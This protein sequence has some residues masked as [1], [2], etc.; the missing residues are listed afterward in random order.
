MHAPNC[1]CCRAQGYYE[2]HDSGHIGTSDL[3]SK[4][5]QYC[6]QAFKLIADPAYEYVTYLRFSA[7]FDECAGRCDHHTR[8]TCLTRQ[9][10]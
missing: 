3:E 5:G 8:H 10:V 1:N 2:I 4:C 6:D 7:D 9:A